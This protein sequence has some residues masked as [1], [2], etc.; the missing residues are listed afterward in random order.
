MTERSGAIQIAGTSDV[1][2]SAELGAGSVVWHLAQVPEDAVLGDNCVVGRGTYVGSGVV[3]GNN[4][5]LQ[6]YAL[7]YETVVSYH[8]CS[9]VKQWSSPTIDTVAARR[10]PWG[11]ILGCKE[12]NSDIAV[13]VYKDASI[14][15]QALQS[16]AHLHV[17]LVFEETPRS[18]KATPCT[19]FRAGPLARYRVFFTP[20]KDYVRG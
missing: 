7:V 15:V 1:A 20:Q 10:R 8:G 5:K 19:G 17:L 12:L 16:I 14:G 6:D 13:V 3:I 11:Q 9:S 2:A 18:P 4:C